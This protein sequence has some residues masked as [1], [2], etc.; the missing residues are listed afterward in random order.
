MVFLLDSRRSKIDEEQKYLILVNEVEL[1]VNNI[2]FLQFSPP[3]G[4]A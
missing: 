2:V 3:R 4:F 1:I